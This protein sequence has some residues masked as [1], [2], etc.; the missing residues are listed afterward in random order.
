MSTLRFR[1]TGTRTAADTLVSRIHGVSGARRVEE[2]DGASTVSLENISS[3]G[4]ADASTCSLYRV[5]VGLPHAA[6]EQYIASV[7]Q[8][9][10]CALGVGVE[11][12]DRF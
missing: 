11:I 12:I 7:L 10:A 9:S 6:N 2:V 5:D 3:T 1:V 8:R 4:G